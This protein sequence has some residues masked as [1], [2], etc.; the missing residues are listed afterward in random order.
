MI[1]NLLKLVLKRKFYSLL[2]RTSPFFGM[3]TSLCCKE[4]NKKKYVAFEM[5]VDATQS[6]P[7]LEDS[8]VI[9]NSDLVPRHQGKG[10]KKGW[11]NTSRHYFLILDND[12][13]GIDKEGNMIDENGVYSNNEK[14][15][16]Q[17]IIVSVA[18]KRLIEIFASSLQVAYEIDFS[19]YQNNKSTKPLEGK[20]TLHALAL[21]TKNEAMKEVINLR[22]SPSLEMKKLNKYNETS[23]YQLRFS[24][25]KRKSMK[26][27]NT[28]K[29]VLVEK[30]LIQ[31]AP[32]PSSSKNLQNQKEQNHNIFPFALLTAGSLIVISYIYKKFQEGPRDKSE[33]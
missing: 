2:L 9:L 11:M 24:K 4:S 32:T 12:E 28:T 33:D 8:L 1:P 19:I 16:K 30:D 7:G 23:F 3:M 6:T 15:E 26:P 29:E 22:K 27:T 21:N 25:I 10:Y 31:E 17:K 14:G 5:K 18:K 13:L 20:E